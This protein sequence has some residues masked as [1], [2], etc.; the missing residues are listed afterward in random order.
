MS[1]IF[2]GYRRDDHTAWMLERVSCC[3]CAGQRVKLIR[4]ESREAPYF[5]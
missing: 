5:F 3:L 4:S 1:A 2:V